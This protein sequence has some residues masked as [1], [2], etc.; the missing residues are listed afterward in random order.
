M[1][2]MVGHFDYTLHEVI[3]SHFLLIG[4][5][6]TSGES[7]VL[8]VDNDVFRLIYFKYEGE[9]LNIQEGNFT[10]LLQL[11]ALSPGNQPLPQSRTHYK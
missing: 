8:V 9:S 2:W 3:L 5:L 6:I 11:D 10:G 1:Q 4:N 7:G